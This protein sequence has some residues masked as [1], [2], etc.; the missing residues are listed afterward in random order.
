MDTTVTDKISPITNPDKEYVTPRHLA[1]LLHQCG[2]AELVMGHN[3]IRQ[4]AREGVIRH[5]QGLTGRSVLIDIAEGVEDILA[6][7]ADLAR[8]RVANN[9]LKTQVKA[10]IRRHNLSNRIN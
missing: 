2:R 10:I 5:I 8:K 1:R 9:T 6:Y 3:Q 4:L 7:R